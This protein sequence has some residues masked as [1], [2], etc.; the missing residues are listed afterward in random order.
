MARISTSEIKKA[1][2]AIE[3]QR[4]NDPDAPRLQ[5]GENPKLQKI[6]QAR[7]RLLVESLESA[8]LDTRKLSALGKQHDT[9]LRR[10]T[11]KYRAEAIRRSRKK[12]AYYSSVISQ[13]KAIVALDNPNTFGSVAQPFLIWA[14][15]RSNI[16]SDSHY[17]PS[18]SWAK[19]RVSTS[20][21]ETH[22]VSFYFLWTNPNSN[23]V[24][25]HPFA[26]VIATG[27]IEADADRAYFLVNTSNAGAE[28]DFY[29]WQW[30]DQSQ[31]PI[32]SA[33]A[34]LGHVSAVSEYFQA[35]TKSQSIAAG[36]ILD[37][38]T[39]F[40][41][42]GSTT[43]L[44]S[45]VSVSFNSNTG[46]ASADFESGNFNLTCPGVVFPITQTPF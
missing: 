35:D 8:G 17:A 2:I 11:E 23:G 34:S 9:E 31:A 21:D 4:S 10:A 46:T 36:F 25:I 22:K 14:T 24:V 41:P 6:K 18:D 42:G 1:I 27:F 29:L 45:A 13:A 39:F 32:L 40:V 3:A 5:L 28:A 30:W 15:P 26:F 19:F 38:G 44:E 43:V 7:N 33:T 12:R 37:A 16:L 20:G